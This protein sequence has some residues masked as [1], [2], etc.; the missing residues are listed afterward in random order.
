MKK[1]AALL[2]TCLCFVS[3]TGNMPVQDTDVSIETIE[4]AYYKVPYPTEET[5]LPDSGDHTLRMLFIRA[6]KAD[7]IIL[8]ADGLTY[9]IDTGEDL[10]VPQILA[11][12][13]YME[14]ESI[15]AVFLTHTD[16]DHIGG[17]NAVRQ[18][19]PI[20]TLYTAVQ[21]EA[22]EIYERL[23]E[24]IPHKLLSA[25]ESAAIG[26]EGLYLDTL[27][28]VLLY[29][30]EENN[31]SLVLRLDC[32]EE[33]ILFTGDMKEAEEADLLATGY[34]LDCTILKVPYHGRK[35]GTGSAFLEA[36]TPEIAIIC[37]DTK[38]DPDTAHKKVLERLRAHGEVFRTEDADLGWLVTTDGVN[39]TITNISVSYPRCADLI[40]ES[41][42]IDSQ[43]LTIRN[44][45]ERA[46][47]S[48]CFVYSDRG[49]ETFVFPQATVIEAGA[50]MTIGCVGTQ[51]DLIWQ[52]ETSV[53]H[54]SKDD[55]A[56]LYDRFGNILDKT[57]AK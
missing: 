51:A 38:T 24:D 4:H 55:N 39:R 23:A 53:W 20:G 45:G 27:C 32:G 30:D 9:L 57:E 43:I 14:T 36:C 28:P 12:L 50:A 29:P 52:G 56:I 5:F 31:N 44:T 41:V 37:S 8:E 1:I 17:W 49:S 26:K 18:A 54:K 16:K 21:M 10:S 11:G 25:G 46:D 22:P 40:I 6:G 33:T 15:E 35:D 34:D 48:G 47:I 7:C 42:S 2:M 13:A 3:C 19:Y